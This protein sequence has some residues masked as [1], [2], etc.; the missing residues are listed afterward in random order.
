MALGLKLSELRRPGGWGLELSIPTAGF[1][2]GEVSD[3]GGRTQVIYCRGNTDIVRRMVAEPQAEPYQVVSVIPSHSMLATHLVRNC[4]GLC[5]NHATV[6]GDV[7]RPGS[8]VV[9]RVSELK[10]GRTYVF[11]WPSTVAPAFPEQL[12]REPLKQRLGW[13][14]ALVTLSHP[15]NPVVQTWLQKFTGLPLT[16]SIPEI[17]PVWPPLTRK[18]TAGFIETFQKAEVV[19]HAGRVTP[20]AIEGVNGL[21][22]RSPSQTI[23]ANAK[24]VNESFFRLITGDESVIQL[25]SQEPARM[26]LT[27][28]LVTRSEFQSGASVELVGMGSNGIVTA[29]ELHTQASA[30]WLDDIRHEKA[31]FLYLA[32]PTHVS[33]ELHVGI[34][35]I[36]ERRLSLRGSGAQTPHCSG[37]RLLAPSITEELVKFILNPSLDVL[38]D[39]GAFGRARSFGWRTDRVTPTISLP[40]ELRGQLLTYLFQTHRR[41]LPALNAR[42]ITDKEIVSTFLKIAPDTTNTASWRTLKAALESSLRRAPEGRVQET[43]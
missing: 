32:L 23:A 14:A 41:M 9:P 21:F 10:I 1:S 33:G 35:G 27:I 20:H 3:V 22:A 25:T 18:I 17:V 5:P 43:K 11:V 34:D 19:L 24:S 7:S 40:L 4:S 36:W 37:S 39:F 38:L 15:L 29:V 16:T 42:Q 8:H 30:A 12:E 13:D 6:F 2:E 26:Q 31:R 28:D